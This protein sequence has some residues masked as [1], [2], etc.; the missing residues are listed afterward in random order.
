M[1]RSEI[2]DTAKSLVTGDRQDEYGTPQLVYGVVAQMMEAYL[3]GRRRAETHITISPE[4]VLIVMA[5]VKI[6]R[7]STGKVRADSYIDLAGY[8]ALAGEVAG[9]GEN[10]ASSL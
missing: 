10:G 9:G 5:L 8:A 7:I 6:G 4:D 2:L 3:N 1:T